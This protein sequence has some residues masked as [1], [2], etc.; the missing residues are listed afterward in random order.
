MIRILTKMII[1]INIRL[2]GAPSEVF[3]LN[4]LRLVFF[5]VFFGLCFDLFW[6]VFFAVFVGRFV[7]AL[8]RGACVRRFV[9]VF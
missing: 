2:T 5:G 3:F 7:L 8:C 1:D 9:F 6:G 4:L